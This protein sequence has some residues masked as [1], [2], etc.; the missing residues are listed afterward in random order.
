MGLKKNIAKT[1]NRQTEGI[2][3]SSTIKRTTFIVNI[4][5]ARGLEILYIS[6]LFLLSAGIVNGLL[7][8]PRLPT[9]YVIFPQRGIQTGSEIFV[10]LFIM[11]MGTLGIYL[12]YMGA[13]DSS[14][15]RVSNFYI[16]FGFSAVLIAV[17]LIFYIFFIKV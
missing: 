2:L 14:K 5:K 15:R 4:I 9:G 16:I 8:G 1:V 7:E 11:V 17:S 6:S 10:Y 12:I 13:R 3:Y